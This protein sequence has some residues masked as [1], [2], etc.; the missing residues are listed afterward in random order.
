MRDGWVLV[1][2]GALA[3]RMRLLEGEEEEEWLRRVMAFDPMHAFCS[4]GFTRVRRVVP[5]EGWPAV[6][7]T[8]SRVLVAAAA[9][10]AAIGAAVTAATTSAAATA[11]PQV[12]KGAG[13]KGAHVGEVVLAASEKAEELIEAPLRGQVGVVPCAHMPFTIHSATS[14][15]TRAIACY[16]RERRV[17]QRFNA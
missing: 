10:A 5:S 11:A 14:S 17:D 4:V 6:R 8:M 3:G 16:Q 9:A 1:A 12:H 15:R 13:F 2:R 7:R